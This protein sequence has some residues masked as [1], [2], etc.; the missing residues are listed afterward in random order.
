MR[1]SNPLSRAEMKM[2]RLLGITYASKNKKV[3][4]LSFRENEKSSEASFATVEQCIN[5]VQA[6]REKGRSEV[7]YH[8]FYPGLLPILQSRQALFSL[9]HK[10]KFRSQTI[11]SLR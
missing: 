9:H 4:T 10:K 1:V 5:S 6:H 8:T 2:R 11:T 7:T 3:I